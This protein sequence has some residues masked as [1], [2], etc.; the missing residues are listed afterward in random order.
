MPIFPCYV[1]IDRVDRA[2]LCGSRYPALMLSS[3]VP[4]AAATYGRFAA[5]LTAAVAAAGP[6]DEIVLANMVHDY[7]DI[8][9]LDNNGTSTQPIVVRSA[10]P[11]GAIMGSESQFRIRG[12]YIRF[13]GI[14]FSGGSIGT[15][16]GQWW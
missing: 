15:Y 9:Y 14:Q 16:L 2:T 10:T 6:G 7:E 5:D 12:D 3:C 1:A 11:L 8:F 13:E 4:A